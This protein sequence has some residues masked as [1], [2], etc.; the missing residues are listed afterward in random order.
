MIELLISIFTWIA[1]TVTFL[2]RFATDNFGT[3]AGLLV[4]IAIT[5]FAHKK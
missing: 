5:A 2:I 4:F 1:E 3:L